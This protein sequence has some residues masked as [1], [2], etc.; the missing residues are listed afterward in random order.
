MCYITKLDQ[1]FK[2]GTSEVTSRFK[3]MTV[4]GRTR[5]DVP[6][7]SH[8]VAA[9]LAFVTT[10]QNLQSVHYDRKE[11][12]EYLPC[13]RNV[14][15]LDFPMYSHILSEKIKQCNAKDLCV[16]CIY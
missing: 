3:R 10:I 7:L 15:G 5:A 16:F 6:I 9:Y 11:F 1:N 4:E 14:T 12:G 13:Q 8:H 2:L